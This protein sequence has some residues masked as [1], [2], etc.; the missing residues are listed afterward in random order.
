MQITLHDNGLHRRFAPISLT[1]PVCEIRFGAK[2][3]RE[4][5]TDL[6]NIQTADCFF[7]TEDYLSEKYPSSASEMLQIAGNIK[8]D[9]ELAEWVSCLKPDEQLIVNDLWIASGGKQADKPVTKKK[10]QLLALRNPWDLFQLADAAIRLDYLLKAS[11]IAQ[12]QVHPTVRLIGDQLYLGKN[13]KLLACT[14]NT[15]TGPV[16]LDDG[17]EIMEGSCIRG[18]FYLGKNSVVKMGAKIYGATSVGPECRVGGEISNSIMLGFSNKGH[19]GFLGNSV[20]G[21]WCNFGANTNT[22]N[23]KN[24]YSNVDFFSMESQ[25][26]VP[27]EVTFL[28]TI[29]GDHSKTGIN[30]MLNTAT[31]VGVSANVFGAGFPSKHIPSFSWSGFGDE[32]FRLDEA[33]RVAR[34]MMKRRNQVLSP[35]DEKILSVLYAM[36]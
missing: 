4:S 35:W 3:I 25:K 32:R 36:A 28:G 8:P 18:P 30:T 24:N 10:E 16:Y 9:K 1:R 6:L 26:A 14:I 15:E 22:S 23:L 20:I 2:T 29:M 5:W 34:I 27:T 12:R 7:S 13:V 21:E 17:A 31:W 19:D 11:N 33:L